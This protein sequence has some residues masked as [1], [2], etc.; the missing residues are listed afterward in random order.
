MMK[1]EFMTVQE[2][3]ERWRVDK[4]SILNAIGKKKIRAI[5]P[6]KRYL[7]STSEVARIDSEYDVHGGIPNA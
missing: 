3:A 1:K 5:R 4:R 6:F 7:I 2:C